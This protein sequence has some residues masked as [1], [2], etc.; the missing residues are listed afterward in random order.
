MLF[1]LCCCWQILALTDYD[2]GLPVSDGEIK[3][4]AHRRIRV[5]Y[6]PRD[7]G[8]FSYFVQL[9]NMFDSRNSKSIPIQCLVSS[10]H[11]YHDISLCHV[12]RRV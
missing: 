11:S 12:L 9:D 10:L 3:S 6:K 5:T 1:H 2:T 7:V 4:C 8:D